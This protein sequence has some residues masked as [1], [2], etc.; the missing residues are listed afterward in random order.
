MCRLET[1]ARLPPDGIS[2]TGEEHPVDG[3]HTPA[4]AEAGC[5]GDIREPSR[6]LDLEHADD[7]QEKLRPSNVASNDMGRSS[8]PSLNRGRKD[9]RDITT[10]DVAGTIGTRNSRPRRPTHVGEPLEQ[11]ERDEMEGLLKEVCGHLGGRF[12]DLW[13]RRFIQ[14][15]LSLVIYPTRFLEGEDVSNNFLFN[16]DRY[17]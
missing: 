11:R 1:I 12:L 10:P 4:V 16:A 9:E 14:A 6:S 15:F 17:V 3:S 13:F 7:G 8:T 5:N 2:T